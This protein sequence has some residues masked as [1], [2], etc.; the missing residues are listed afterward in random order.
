MRT[1]NAHKLLSLLLSLCMVF[2]LLPASIWAAE[3]ATATW[4]KT[5]LSQ[6][7]SEDTVAITMTKGD[8]TWVLPANAATTG[9][10][11][12]VATVSGDTLTTDS[13]NYGWTISA[14]TDGYT[15]QNKDGKSLYLD[16]KGKNNCVRVGDTAASWTVDTASGYLTAKDTDGTQ[17]YLGVYVDKPDWRAYN[18]TTGNTAGQTLGIW[19]LS[20]S[21]TPV[22]PQPDDPTPDDPQA[23]TLTKL[24]EAPADGD[25]V[26]ICNPASSVVMSLTDYLFNNKKHELSP[27]N[28]TIEND[29][30]SVSDETIA[31]LTVKVDKDG[32]YSFVNKDGKYLEVDGTNVQFVD[33]A[34]ANTLFQLETAEGG[35]YVKC[36]SATYSGKAQYLQYYHDYFTCYSLNTSYPERYVFNFYGEVKEAKTGLVTDLADLTDGS[37]V[38]IYN[39]ASEI[40]MTSETYQDWYLLKGEATIEN[41][42]VAEPADNQIWKVSVSDDGVYTFTQDDKAVTAWLSGTFV[43]LTSDPNHAGADTGW[44]LD[45]CNAANSTFYMRSNTLT[46]KYGASYVEVY[47]KKVNNVTTRVF[48]GYSTDEGSLTEAAF[49]MQFYLLPSPD[50]PDQPEEPTV[51]T[52]GLTSALATGDKVIL[53]NDAN[54]KGISSTVVG[55]YYLA[56][57]D[58]TPAEG[59]IT[60]DDASVVWDVTVNNDGTYTFTQGSKVLGGVQSTNATSGKI[61]NNIAL[62][63]PAASKWT[64][65]SAANGS[66]L[67]L[68]EL[69]SSKTGGHIY[70]DW[71]AKYSE[72]SLVDYSNPG[73]N[74][75]FVFNFY[76]QGAEPETPDQPGENGDLITSLADLKDGSTVAI[77]SP[78]HKTA[79]SSKPNGD[80]YL[81]ANAATVNKDGKVE[82][83]TEDMIWTVK[84]NADSNTYSFYAYGDESRSITV[85][86]SGNYAELS[87]DVGKYPDNTWTLTPAKTAN[88]FY[89]NSPTVSGN[90]GPAYI[91]AYVRNDT[92]VF[93]GYFTNPG[94]NKFVENEF[95]LQFYL[96]NAD[97]AIEAYDDGEWDGVLNKGD[98]Y[99]IYNSNAESS[100]GLA[101]EATYS[102]TAVPTTIEGG[103]AKAGNGAYVF[104]VDTMGRYYSFEVDGKY[105]ATNN[106]EELFFVDKDENGKLP[107]TAKWFLKAKEGGYVIYNKEAT[108]GG[109]PVC[110]EYFSSVFS[111]WTFNTKNDLA[112]YL[113]NFYP[114]AEGTKIYGDIVQDPSVVFDCEDSRYV[115]Q[116]YVLSFS[117]DDLAPEIT[118][119]TITYTAGTKTGTVEQT[120]DGKAYSVTIPAADIDVADGL[121]SFTIKV[122]VKN[123]YGIEYEGEKVVQIVDEPFFADLT[124]APNSQ[125]RDEKKPTISAKVGNV[126]E[127]PTFTMTVNDQVVE[128]RYENGALSYTPAA[129]LADGRVTVKI[130]VTR[131]DGVTAEKIWTFTVGIAEYQLYFGQLHSHTTYSDGS[132]SLETALDYV[133]SLPESANVQFV[134]FTDHSNYFDTTSAANPADALND[135]SLMTEASRELWNTYKNTVADFNEK[136]TGLIAIAGFEMTWSGGPGHIN[137][138]DSD[139]LVS[140]N[141]AEL[142]NKSGDAGMKLYYETINKG[143][144]LNQFN[145]PGTTFGNFTDFSYWDEET[146]EH[147]FLVEV[148]NGEGQIGAGGYYPSYEQYTMALDKGWHV[149]PTNNQDNHKGRWGNANDARDV[150]LT[151]DFSEQGIYNA[152]RALRV[153][154]TEDKNLQINYT[155]NGEPMGTIF[156]DE[157]APEKLNIEVTLYDPDASDSIAKVELVCNNG[158]VA[159][160]WDNAAELAEG[161]LTV[162]LEPEY[163]YYF[164]RVTQKDGDL[165]V[166]SPVWVGHALKVGITD[167]KAASEPVYKG[168][169]ATLT[170]NLFNSEAQ[171]ATVKSLVYTVGG[172]VIGTDSQTYTIK[173]GSTL[174]VTF[175]HVFDTAKLTTVTVTAIVEFEGKEYTYSANV[176]LDILDKDTEGKVTPIK[177]VRDASKPD[178]TGYRFTIE[179]V[180]TSN[181][182]GY[183][184]DTAFF[185]CIY[186]QDDTAGICCFP[187]SGEYKVGD[188]VR[189]VGHT[190]F[191]Q[192]EPELQVQTIEVIGTGSVEPT[193]IAAAELNDRSAEGKLVTVKGTVES[194]EL[195]NGLI[196]TIM[197]KD[198]AG[199]LARVFIDGYITTAKEVENCVVGAKITVTGLASY[200]DTFNAPEGPFPRIR[201]RDRADVVCQAYQFLVDDRTGGKAAT[202]IE[203]GTKFGPGELTFTVACDEP[204]VVAVNNGDGTYTLLPCTTEGKEH[205]FTVT[206]VDA[207]VTV[208]IALK[209]DADLNGT[210]ALK[211]STLTK[212]VAAGLATFDDQLSA[213]A[214]DFDGNG[215]FNKDATK[216]SQVVAGLS[217]Y[218]W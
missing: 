17:R 24:T 170:T 128:A 95:A 20:G 57:V 58:L 25:Q 173:A 143:E 104:T 71:Y 33:A 213:L 204:C 174:D 118:D 34:S 77:Y 196:Q 172:T 54:K 10:A 5:D 218:N 124:P 135:Q 40:A 6:I 195:A 108:Y 206:I 75:A 87:V 126:G 73:T 101:K 85:W 98:Q 76:K 156:T 187:V 8:T 62:N 180:V 52:Y 19:K 27:V 137:T 208:S 215:V 131:A 165:A 3:P 63:N 88:C 185:D 146:D 26:V 4:T 46:T 157:N 43:E 60:T 129:D 36:D 79:I 66:Y 69:P 68:G 119:V 197:V 61:Y 14:V 31:Y 65:E 164:V 110:I 48:C 94:S 121:T 90:N 120:A 18:N 30:M 178:D 72:F 45:V 150:I 148:G 214:V 89:A 64:A 190:D 80:W 160:T 13:G 210:V 2:S 130:T 177:D 82:N 83:F 28:V 81:K 136:H 191:Y 169:T 141:N 200:D 92:E 139:G 183:D 22:D 161:S 168:E 11:A 149:A 112:I 179:G 115:E 86:P 47:N 138:F 99:V 125:T 41:G 166:T 103:K 53:F 111:G 23:V 78:G 209:G 32:K 107:E 67:Y 158:A 192:G 42:E 145:H 142:N 74:S 105:L 91:E 205:Q 12:I 163:S 16:S 39:P 100:L 113:F 21:E 140:R 9:P 154:A 38:V 207:D 1:R 152:I 7:T 199:N 114:V 217:S 193:E 167:I 35:Y 171:D 194:F 70:I 134:A 176:E 162:E 216:I 44:K 122:T 59:V 15:I 133:A 109:N 29:Q 56:G 203:S 93:S 184:K 116:D 155:L 51:N 117:L 49:G 55:S 106:E 181:A 97:D 37:Y 102:L 182:S 201:I 189:I 123:S 84:V 127:N 212:R 188:K 151:N 132:G 147:M 159:H 144:S 186:V 202:S 50:E 211:D 96:V 153:Y 198:E 175:D